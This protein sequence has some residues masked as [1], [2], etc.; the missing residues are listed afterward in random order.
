MFVLQLSGKITDQHLFYG[1]NKLYIT[2]LGTEYSRVKGYV[3][4][5]KSAGTQIPG[6]LFSGVSLCKLFIVTESQAL[7]RK[8]GFIESIKQ[9]HD[10]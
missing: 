10:L 7:V 2:F 1:L 4:V 8:I 6:A 9:N 3:T 5:V